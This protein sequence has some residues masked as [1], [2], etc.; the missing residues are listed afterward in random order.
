MTL[1]HH[2]RCHDR[3]LDARGFKL[4][5]GGGVGKG[6]VRGGSWVLRFLFSKTKC[7]S[8]SNKCVYCRMY[9]CL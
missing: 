7:D 2:S 1:S 5:R 8:G 3:T 6:D 4:D 9:N